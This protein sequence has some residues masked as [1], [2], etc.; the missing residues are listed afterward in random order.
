MCERAAMLWPVEFDNDEAVKPVWLRALHSCARHP[1]SVRQGQAAPGSTVSGNGV[2]DGLMC[3]F[4][5]DAGNRTDCNAHPHWPER[6]ALPP[7][8]R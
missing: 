2:I 5:R 8:R 7:W 4:W 3:A 6:A 1:A